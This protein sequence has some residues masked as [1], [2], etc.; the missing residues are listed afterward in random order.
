MVRERCATVS[1]LPVFWNEAWS[2]ARSPSRNHHQFTSICA[3]FQ[4]SLEP[5]P[6]Y[7]HVLPLL[8]PT[9][10]QNSCN[11]D[12]LDSSLGF[13][14]DWF[15]F[16]NGCSAFVFGLSGQPGAYFCW[17]LL[18]ADARNKS[19]VIFTVRLR[20]SNMLMIW[21]P[22]LLWLW[23]KFR[24][25]G[26]REINLGSALVVLSPRVC[27]AACHFRRPGINQLS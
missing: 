16:W 25:F 24:P 13:D 17:Y 4:P 27:T 1:R 8:K 15:L 22:Q 26:Y 2:R 9:C 7:R 6:R 12:K 11:N 10:Y 3:A 5:A 14:R 18:P 23:S 21:H 20:Y 19:F